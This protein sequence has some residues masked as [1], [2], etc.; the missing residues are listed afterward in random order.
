MVDLP[1]GPTSL[2]E[3]QALQPLTELRPAFNLLLRTLF[4]NGV[5]GDD[6]RPM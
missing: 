5:F 3:F 4:S 6:R 1:P 2:E